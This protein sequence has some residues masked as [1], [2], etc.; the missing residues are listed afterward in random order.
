MALRNQNVRKNEDSM[1]KAK[2]TTVFFCQKCG[3]ESSKWMGQ[4]PGCKEWNTFA[5]ETLSMAKPSAGQSRQLTGG[6]KR[7]EPS[8]LSA[9]TMQEEDRITTRIKELDRVLGGGI[10]SGSLTLVGGDPG[11]GKSTLLLQVCRNLAEDGRKVLYISGEE[12]LKQIKIR[13]M[14]IGEFR[15]TL[16]LLCETNLTVIE[17]TIRRCKPEMVVIDSIQT[18][19]DEAVSSAPGS[20]SQVRESTGVLLQIAKGLGVSVFIVG[21]VTKEGTVAGP[22]VLEHM[23]DTVLYFE[24]DRHAS[25]RILR[26]VKNRFGSTNEIGVF[27]MRREG[28]VEVQNP[29]EFML[30]GKPEGASGS[31]VVCSMEGTRPILIEIQALVCQSNFGIPRRQTTGTDFNRVNLLMAVLEKRLGL[32]MSGCDAYVNIAGGMK[33]N[34]PAL[35]LGMVM[36]IASSYK[37]RAIDEKT[38]VFG[39]IGL[40]GEVR[41]VSMAEQRVLEAAKLG[42]T[43]CIL[44]ESC[45][46]GIK[47]T[48]GMKLIGVKSVQEAIDSI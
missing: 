17:E 25:Y 6:A 32:Q 39:E 35:D 28:L 24:G 45:K 48:E 7:A 14:R 2:M 11:I 43:T 31:V 13:A 19:Y 37:N 40:S 15:D 4:C 10:V 44:P 23:V 38:V 41:A 9:I 1:A 30:N 20:V 22:R 33:M 18:M 8:S 34:E 5:E 46:K 36:A 3:Y 21:H 29:S 26:G 47:Q 12:S 16:L 42:F 27:E